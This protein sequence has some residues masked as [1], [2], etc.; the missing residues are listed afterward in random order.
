MQPCV[1]AAGDRGSHTGAMDSDSGDDAAEVLA[2]LGVRVAELE[3]RMRE[4]DA[5]IAELEGAPSDSRPSRPSSSAVTRR[6]ATPLHSNAAASTRRPISMADTA[7]IQAVVARMSETPAN[8]HQFCAFALSRKADGQDAELAR[9]GPFLFCISC[10]IVFMQCA[11]I[12]GVFSGTLWKPC[13]SNSL[14]PS[15]ASRLASLSRAGRY[16]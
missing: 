3:A 5:R 6:A 11:T 15:S 4:R 1:A 9:W 8:W 12:I 10:L 2:A 16:R 13:G 7:V 14:A